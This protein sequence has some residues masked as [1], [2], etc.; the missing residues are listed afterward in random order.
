MTGFAALDNSLLDFVE[1]MND[2]DAIDTAWEKTVR[3]MRS[4]GASHVGNLLDLND[5]GLFHLNTSSR[6]VI[7]IY[8][9]YVYPD[10]DPKRTHCQN[11]VT[12]YFFGQEFWDQEPN[13]SDPRRWCDEEL[14]DAGGRALVAIPIHMPHSKDW[15]HVSIATDFCREEFV[16]FYNDRGGKLHVAAITAFNRIY[17]LAKNEEAKSIGL[18][19]RE[20]EVLLWLGRGLLADRIAERL[21]IKTITVSFHLANAR[22]KLNARTSAQALVKSVQFGLIDP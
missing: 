9:E 16:S 17:N 4:L 20:R 6:R 14:V 21:N 7:E 5:S 15:G 12:P 13:L 3:Y 10:H 22:R 2:V 11:N 1:T 19:D 8:R 18:T